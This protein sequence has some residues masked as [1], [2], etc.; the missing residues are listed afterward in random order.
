LPN[1]NDF[2]KYL[3]AGYKDVV[4]D[5]IIDVRA[6]NAQH[7]AAL[8]KE[9]KKKTDTELLQELHSFKTQYGARV[10]KRVPLL[11]D[12]QRRLPTA[13]RDVLE[14]VSKALNL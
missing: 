13:I 11:S 8:E 14:K 6:T 1:G 4:V 7:R 9:W 12:E 10:G 5:M 3:L 2:E